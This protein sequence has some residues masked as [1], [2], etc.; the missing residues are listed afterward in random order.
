MNTEPPPASPY[1]G[2]AKWRAAGAGF[3]FAVVAGAMTAVVFAIPDPPAA[4]LVLGAYGAFSTALLVVM[5]LAEVRTSRLPTVTQSQVDGR[6]AQGVQARR[7][8]WWPGLAHSVADTIGLVLLGVLGISAG[9]EWTPFG[10][11]ALAAATWPLGRV[12]WALAGRR[13]NDALWVTSDEVVGLGGDGSRRC[14]HDDVIKVIAGTSTD[15]VIV[16]ARHVERRR[17]PRPWRGRSRWAEDEIG[18]DC[19]LTAH[20]PRGLATWLRRQTGVPDHT[21]SDVTR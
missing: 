18:I 4:M 19:S 6:P 11:I 2:R 5:A 16:V 20:D 12:A 1:A 14:T 15:T 21:A 17:C 8:E 9:G 7:A 13:H 10:A 3:S